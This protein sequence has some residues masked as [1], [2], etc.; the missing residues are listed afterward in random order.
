MDSKQKQALEAYESYGSI[1]LAAE[2]LGISKS[3][4]Q[5]RIKAAEQNVDYELPNIPDDDM[6]VD[7]LVEHLT[8]RFAKRKEHK[9]ATKW[10]TIKMKSNQPIGLLWFG[11]PHI[12]D[13]YCDW[14]SLHRDLAIVESQSAIYGCSLGDH[15][16]NWVGRLGRLYGEQDTSHKTAWKLVEWLIN[17]M[18]PMVLI[19][20]NHD[21]WSGAGDPLKWMTGLNTVREDWEARICIEFPN[22]RQCRIHA[23]H[24]MP[25]HSQWNSL[26]AQNKMARFK[27]HAHLYISGHRHNWGLAQIEDVERKSTAWLA[28]A[29]GYKFHDTY[30]FVKGFEQQNFGQSIMQVIDPQ[31]DSPVS[32]TQCFAD[33]Q[34][35]ADYLAFRQSLQQ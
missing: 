27:S 10:Y 17:K 7:M 24:D 16:N 34:E 14:E 2:A 18:N 21:M 5:R 29:R 35:G 26:H 3:E 20:G 31:N 6:P 4:A 9:E 28:R 11:D 25:G 33:P 8:Q 19:G 13:N 23:A 12:D 32:W 1:R 15:Q 30:A 22:G